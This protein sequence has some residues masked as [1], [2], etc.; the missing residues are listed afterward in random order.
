MGILYQ[1]VSSVHRKQSVS[2]VCEEIEQ[3]TADKNGSDRMVPGV[4][5]W[6]LPCEMLVQLRPENVPHRELES[7]WLWIILLL[8]L[9]GLNVQW[10]LV[11]P[12]RPRTLTLTQPVDREV[13]A[14]SQ[15]RRRCIYI[16]A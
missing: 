8:L 4:I 14:K 7:R 9:S 5:A 10:E 11:Y 6:S 12:S 2:R 15:G 3:W 16:G 13:V 1:L